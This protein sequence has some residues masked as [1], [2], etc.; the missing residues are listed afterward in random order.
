MRRSEFSTKTQIILSTV[1]NICKELLHYLY[2]SGFD[3]GGEY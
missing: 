3:D 1:N 2:S